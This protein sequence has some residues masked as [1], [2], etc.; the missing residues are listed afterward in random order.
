MTSDEQAS[1]THGNTVVTTKVPQFITLPAP[2]GGFIMLD[3]EDDFVYTAPSRGDSPPQPKPGIKRSPSAPT[4]CT[5]DALLTAA[6]SSLSV[7]RGSPL[8]LDDISPHLTRREIVEAAQYLPH[9]YYFNPLVQNRS[10]LSDDL[11]DDDIAGK[12]QE[13]S[14][15]KKK[16]FY[17]CI[18]HDH[19]AYRYELLSC[20]GTGTFGDVMLAFDHKR[21]CEV[22]IKIVSSAKSSPGG[23]AERELQIIQ[24]LAAQDDSGIDRAD[25]T[26]QITPRLF[27]HFKFRGHTCMV[28]ESLRFGNLH[29]RMKLY[30][31]AGLVMRQVRLLTASIVRCLRDI[32]ARGVIHCDIKPENLMLTNAPGTAMQVIDFGLSYFA[33]KVPRAH[34]FG[35]KSFS[36]P[37][38]VIGARF[39]CSIDM[40]SLGCVVAEMC[41]GEVLFPCKDQQGLMTKIVE[42]LGMPPAH[43]IASGSRSHLFFNQQQGKWRVG[44]GTRET[45][46]GSRPLKGL[47]RRTSDLFIVHFIES[48]LQWDAKDRIT[49]ELA[50]D[51][52]FLSVGAYRSQR[53]S[54]STAATR[55]IDESSLRDTRS[56][57]TPSQASRR[58]SYV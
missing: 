8:T 56:T 47:L 49:A 19:I 11:A 39:D 45:E 34:S 48:C 7:S 54:I 1:R 4:A 16:P 44:G 25:N 50:M 43:V 52:P 14:P 3:D 57:A 24:H 36:A 22:A 23:L 35:S 37:E 58:F 13:E 46:P 5:H 6:P 41:T 38:V 17:R 15:K 40:W 10:T 31:Q 29:D 26:Q 30:G 18:K 32:H 42:V 27:A 51:H 20:L 21:Q 28:F 2:R 53:S 12:L 55:D 9:L 33:D